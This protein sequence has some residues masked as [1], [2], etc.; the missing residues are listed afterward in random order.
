MDE[1]FKKINE[2]LFEY[3][4]L[5]RTLEEIQNKIDEKIRLVKQ[6]YEDQIFTI[7]NKLNIKK[8]TIINFIIDNENLFDT[9]RSKKL[10]AGTIGIRKNPT[11]M[12]IE[13]EEDLIEELERRR[14]EFVIKTTKKISKDALKTYPE[15]LELFSKYIQQIDDETA[16][17]SPIKSKITISEIITKKLI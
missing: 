6:E 9:E 2:I 8:E 4:T 17:F 5:N 12:I 13:N 14:M 15:I 7:E 11:K 10:P 1:N 3:S 16:F